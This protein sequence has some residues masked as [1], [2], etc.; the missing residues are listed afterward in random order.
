MQTKFVGYETFR[1]FLET[2]QLKK[3][4]SVIV[5]AGQRH[6]VDIEGRLRLIISGE[7][8]QHSQ[9]PEII[10]RDSAEWHI[11]DEN[12]RKTKREDI[13]N[14]FILTQLNYVRCFLAGI[15]SDYF[16]G[17]TVIHLAGESEDDL[18]ASVCSGKNTLFIADLGGQ[19]G[20]ERRISFVLL[21][22][23]F[24]GIGRG[25]IFTGMIAGKTRENDQN[26]LV[27]AGSG[28]FLSIPASRESIRKKLQ[29]KFP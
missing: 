10:L 16:K 14:I 7:I 20:L 21:A 18:L 28:L 1:H 9:S 13:D 12:S 5:V 26:V 8:Q 22:Q 6:L 2:E 29:Q 25:K 27:R 24:G 23:T 17:A 3:L 19:D 4:Q 15:L 11:E